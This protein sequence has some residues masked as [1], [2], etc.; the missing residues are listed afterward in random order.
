[1]GRVTA[2][3]P[4]SGGD[5]SAFSFNDITVSNRLTADG[6][7]AHV[8]L[9]GCGVTVAATARLSNEATDGQNILQASAQLARPGWRGARGVRVVAVR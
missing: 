3:G 7:K 5:I 8:A 2:I 1:M 9:K 4:V 6:P